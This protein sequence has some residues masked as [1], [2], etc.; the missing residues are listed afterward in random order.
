[1]LHADPNDADADAIEAEL[2]RRLDHAT[3]TADSLFFGPQ[4]RAV[5][6]KARRKVYRCGRRSGKTMGIAGELLLDVTSPPY[7]NVFYVTTTLKNAKRL[8]WPTIKA[9]NTKYRLGGVPNE[10]EGYMSFPRLGNDCHLYLGGLNDKGEA[11]KLRGI[12][13]KRYVIDEAQLVRDSI[14]RPTMVEI[15]GP[16]LMDYAGVLV[17]AGT[18]GPTKTGYFFEVDQG[19]ASEK[20][21][22]HSW[23]VRENERLPA[24]LAGISIDAILAAVREDHGWTEESPSYRREYEGEWCEDKDALVFDY[25]PAK[26]DFDEMPEGIDQFVHAVDL[27]WEDE[28]AIAVLGWSEQAPESYLASEYVQHRMTLTELV[29]GHVIPMRNAYPPAADVWDFGGLGKK[30][31]MEVRDRW[32]IPVEA[33]ERS[34]KFEHIALLNDAMRTGKFKARRTS[35]FAEDC[36]L[37]QWEAG[38][39]GRVISDAYH[40]NITDAVLY[41]FRKVSAYMFEPKAQG[42]HPDPNHPDAVFASRAA[43]IDRR[44]RGEWFDQDAAMMGFRDPEVIDGDG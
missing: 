32:G 31:G 42:P 20:W 28:D 29:E 14:L 44:N 27:G 3:F 25:N 1:M 7:T 34:R 16:A 19:K 35:R 37:V 2:I 38:E 4:R 33:A 30:M 36:K 24:R 6:S 22:R 40:S 13:G 12:P 10:S 5:A 43:K 26:Q 15:I 18:P 21:D 9:L 41:G 17:V 11:E 39:R 23:T 8:I